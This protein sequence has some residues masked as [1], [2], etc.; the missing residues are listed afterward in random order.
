MDDFA[1][2]TLTCQNKLDSLLQALSVGNN[3][4]VPGA[5]IS[6]SRWVGTGVPSRGCLAR[7]QNHTSSNDIDLLRRRSTRNAI[8]IDLG[9][10]AP[11]WVPRAR[12][13][14]TGLLYFFRRGDR[15][16]RTGAPRSAANGTDSAGIGG[17]TLLLGGS[18]P[19]SSD[20]SVSSTVFS[21][22]LKLGMNLE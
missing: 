18:V 19:D 16:G 14:E 15:R 21:S 9:G 4:P 6:R 2:V 11:A 5:A 22:L 1:S 10:S 8:R 13:T 12:V 17:S 7:R 3:L 20:S